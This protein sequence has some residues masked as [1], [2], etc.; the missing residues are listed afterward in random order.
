MPS[1]PTP[2]PAPRTA[3]EGRRRNRA[4]AAGVLLFLVIC[5]IATWQ[6]TRLAP[7]GAPAYE[8][9]TTGAATLWAWGG[10]AEGYTRVWH[11]TAGPDSTATDLA[12]IGTSGRFVAWDHGC[13]KVRPGF[14]GG[15]QGTVDATWVW[16]GSRWR[17]AH[18]TSS[19]VASGQGTM[20]DDRRLGQALYVN[21]QGRVW[22]WTG[23][24]WMPR[25]EHGGPLVPAPG[26]VSRAPQQAF[27]AG[28]DD[29][30]GDL[31][32][33]RTQRTWLWDGAAWTSRP[34]GIDVADQGSSV[35]LTD[36]VAAGRMVYAGAHDTW[37]WDG[38]AWSHQPHAT[39]PEGSFAYDP[40]S[41]RVVLVAPDEND[42][43]RDGCVTT[44]WTWDGGAW[45]RQL[46]AEPA[47]LPST[48]YS[49]QP[50]PVA[51]DPHRAAL[52]VLVSSN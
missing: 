34:G 36:D 27:A 33:V 49:D 38:S 28:Y 9:S 31:V 2:L 50:P 10:G 43:G 3:G 5:A 1:V 25:A 4:L 11:A 14:D 40:R 17:R 30:T 41:G 12:A 15:C 8:T 42:C 52:L 19:P 22:A 16:N 39:L 18:P 21:G 51:Y 48:R 20:V 13:A 23:R 35:Q 24:T 45:T 32:I 46:L 47:L 44:T 7:Q 6:V 29:A 26:T 37:T